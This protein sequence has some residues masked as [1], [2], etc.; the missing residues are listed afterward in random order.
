MAIL[1]LCGLCVPFLPGSW[2]AFPRVMLSPMHATRVLATMLR[3]LGVRHGDAE[4]CR[5]GVVIP[6]VR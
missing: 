5:G 6:R 1:G 4:C 2:L 3:R